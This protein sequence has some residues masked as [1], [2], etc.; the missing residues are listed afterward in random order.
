MDRLVFF[1]AKEEK[2]EVLTTEGVQDKR[3]AVVYLKRQQRPLEA[4][5]EQDRNQVISDKG[6]RYIISTL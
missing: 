5:V 6:K 3:Y 2:G 1:L 4:L